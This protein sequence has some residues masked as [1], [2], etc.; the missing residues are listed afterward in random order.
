MVTVRDLDQGAL[1]SHKPYL[2]VLLRNKGRVI[3]PEKLVPGGLPAKLCGSGMWGYGSDQQPSLESRVPALDWGVLME[4]DGCRGWRRPGCRFPPAKTLW[5]SLQNVPTLKILPE[6][7][8]LPQF[9]FLLS[10]GFSTNF[11]S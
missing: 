8:D 4:P 11:S 2:R 3:W 6:V 9:V 1:K 7:P 5:L 10:P